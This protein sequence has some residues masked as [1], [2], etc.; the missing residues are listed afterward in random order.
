MSFLTACATLP[1]G[2]IAPISTS[3]CSWVRPIYLSDKSIDALAKAGVRSDIKAV[4]DH[5]LVFERF[6]RPLEATQ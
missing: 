6:C 5:N 1:G 4:N 3:G 2:G